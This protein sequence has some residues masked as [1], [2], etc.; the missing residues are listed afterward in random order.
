MKITADGIG[1]DIEMEDSS[2]GEILAR[3]DDRIDRAG[4]VMV[5][6]RLDGRTLGPDD[7]EALAD[8][9]AAEFHSLEADTI[10]ASELRIRAYETII[11]FLE[12]LR[13]WA[14]GSVT[15]FALK[16]DWEDYRGAYS[17][18]LSAD[19][20][21]FL[22]LMG[23][24][25]DALPLDVG[26]MDC[27]RMER[28]ADRLEPVFR[29]R[30]EEILRP[31]EAMKSTAGL[32]AAEME[33]LREVPVRLQTGKDAEAIRSIL[34][35]VEI[36]HK[37][38]RILPELERAGTDTT[39]LRIEGRTLPEFYEAFNNTLRLLM[40]AFESHDYVT[41]GD[42]AEYEIVPRMNAFF[43]TIAGALEP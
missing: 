20:H 17:G 1:L 23:R 16:K 33:N 37:A 35:F 11:G 29:E 6:L 26:S 3:A 39:V 40:A 10:P 34:E 42:L 28:H 32:Y 22:D 21:S 25:L 8:R 15:A 38:N 4:S 43:G 2:L 36:F 24:D 7:I 27:G 5:A 9:P 13:G 19:E 12:T 14:A 30:L 41:I 31:V 18:L